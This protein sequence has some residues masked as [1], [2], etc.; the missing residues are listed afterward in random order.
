LLSSSSTTL[1][2][3]EQALG[4]GV[5]CSMMV[6]AHFITYKTNCWVYGGFLRDFV[7][8]GRSHAEMDLDVALP[9]DGSAGLQGVLSCIINDK[10]GL[11]PFKQ[12]R[13]K[14]SLVL[15]ATFEAY[16]RSCEFTIEIVDSVAFAKQEPPPPKVDFDVNNLRLKRSDDGIRASLDLKYPA[17]GTVESIISHINART[18]KL[19]K[20]PNEISARI[21]KMK[22]RGW[23]IEY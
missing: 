1:S 19:V 6:L 16:D 10:S 11:P 22:Q 3:F 8:T 18:L 2:Q 4:K 5:E 17:Q 14:G 12:Q 21:T 7:V 13:L 15:E 23:T 20:R 9:R